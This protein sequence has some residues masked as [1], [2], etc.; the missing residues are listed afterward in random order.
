MQPVIEKVARPLP[1]WK[2]RMLNRSGHLILAWSTLC[3]IP[4]HISMAT[5]IDPWV[6]QVIEKLVHGFLW[7]GSEVAVGGVRLLRSIRLAQ[8]GTVALASPIFSLWAS[9]YDFIGYGWLG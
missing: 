3:V 8:G 2:G 7:F 9:H 5:S 1:P 4:M 6:I